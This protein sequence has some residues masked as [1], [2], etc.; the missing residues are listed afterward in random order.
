MTKDATCTNNWR[1]FIGAILIL[2]PEIRKDLFHPLQVPPVDRRPIGN[3]GR[4]RTQ[5][6]WT[7]LSCGG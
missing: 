4:R 2:T 7:T 3:I 5:K 6:G 1:L